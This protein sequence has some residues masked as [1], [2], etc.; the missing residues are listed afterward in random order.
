MT[1][2]RKKLT[3]PATALAGLLLAVPGLAA[4]G[5]DEDSA[6]PGGEVHTAANGAEYNDA[7]VAFATDMIPH[8]AQATEMV[9]MARGRGLDA[10]VQAIA[11]AILT[12]QPA[13]VETMVDWLTDWGEPIP[14]TSQDHANA[15]GEGMEPD[16]DLPG[17]M[18]E[19]EMAELDA[20][21]GEE[22]QTMWLEMMIEHHEGAI[23]MAETEIETGKYPDA[24]KLAE[25]IDTAQAAEIEQMQGLLG[26]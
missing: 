24:V 14:P 12:A 1:L 10:E 19:D 15:H 5:N 20:A 9:S 6:D 13:E 22:F 21:S 7:D 23:E 11:D 26:S 4:C 18:S 25:S 3:R 8:H 17:M 2:T 16:T